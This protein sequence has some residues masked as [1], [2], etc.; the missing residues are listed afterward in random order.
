MRLMRLWLVPLLFASLKMVGCS[1]DEGA[2]APKTA[3]TAR[4]TIFCRCPGTG[5]GGWQTCLPDGSGFDACVPC[6]GSNV[7]PQ[8]GTTNPTFKEAECGNGK[9][10]PGEQCDDGNFDDDD[11]CLSDC[12]KAKCGDGIV[13]IGAED[14]DDANDDDTDGCTSDCKI[15]TPPSEK[16][17]GDPIEVTADPAGKKVTGNF[18]ALQPNHEGTCGGTG[19][20]AVYSFVAPANGEAIVS[21][22]VLDGAKPDAAIYVRAD[23]CENSKKEVACANTGKAGANELADPFPVTKGSTYYVFVDSQDSTEGGFSLRVRF[24]PDEA[25]DGQGGPCEVQDTAVKGECA[26]GTLVCTSD[27]L[28][29]QPAASVA[30]VCG[31][32]KDDDCDGYVDNGCTCAHDT[33]TIGTALAPDC[34]DSNNAV[35]PCI[36]TICD[37]DDYCCGKEWDDTCV[38]EVLTLCGTGA[39]VKESCAHPLCQAG[40]KLDSGCDGAFKCV[41]AVCKTDG[42]CCGK[43]WDSSCVEKVSQICGIKCQ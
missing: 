31:N 37:K 30:E 38:G 3:C 29:C 17:P 15:K 23:E 27:K 22:S 8:E 16:C 32:G 9:E 19:N 10:E 24:R 34:K 12:R 25:C 6:D 7:D 14:C 28:V 11:E 4:K 20:D 41:E 2:E 39:C 26:A 40:A 35:D 21:I 43:E 33:C 5:E 1:K 36:K 13:H 42:F 18:K